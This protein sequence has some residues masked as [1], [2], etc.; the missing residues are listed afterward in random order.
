MIFIENVLNIYNNN[1]KTMFIYFKSIDSYLTCDEYPTLMTEKIIKQYNL[2]SKCNKWMKTNDNDGRMFVLSYEYK[3][4][5]CDCDNS[6]FSEHLNSL[7]DCYL[8]KKLK[9]N[10]HDGEMLYLQNSGTE[11]I[12]CVKQNVTLNCVLK[13]I[14]GHPNMYAWA[15]HDENNIHTLHVQKSNTTFYLSDS[16]GKVDE[17]DCHMIFTNDIENVLYYEH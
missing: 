5:I 7:Y 17:M 11:D 12:V 9:S 14:D 8:C 13:E 2:E 4:Q 3:K 6:M 1:K 10:L 15:N 16:N